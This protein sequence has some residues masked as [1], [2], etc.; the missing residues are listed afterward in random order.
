[1]R[2]GVKNGITI[3][4][5]VGKATWGAGPPV[6]RELIARNPLP[7]KMGPSQ[8]H[9]P[10]KKPGLDDRPRSNNDKRRIAGGGIASHPP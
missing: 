10:K 2:D 5:G 1:L 4:A 7:E 6:S 9:A 8:N 3:L